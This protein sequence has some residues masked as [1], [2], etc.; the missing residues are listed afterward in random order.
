MYKPHPLFECPSDEL[1]IWRYMDLFKF[2]DILNY[3]ALYLPR[4][5]KLVKLDE[6][7]GGLRPAYEEYISE[8]LFSANFYEFLC[9]FGRID[10][11]LITG[12]KVSDL[13]KIRERFMEVYNYFKNN[14]FV[15]FWHLNSDENLDMWNEYIYSPPGVAV[16]SSVGK[17]KQSLETTDIP[18][19]LSKVLYTDW[20][21]NNIDFN[22]I[23]CGAGTFLIILQMLFNKA[24]RYKKENELRILCTTLPDDKIYGP[25]LGG[26]FNLKRTSGESRLLLPIES[27][28]L[29]DKI[30]L[31]PGS[32]PEFRN[33]IIHLV[34]KYIRGFDTTKIVFSKFSK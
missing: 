2:E 6:Y 34:S 19:T 7:E 12:N 17:L 20:E 15:N 23:F 24:T 3:R 11:I 33:E 21:N 26:G 1:E 5:D 10:D 32:T 18:I 28:R 22:I 13:K 4:A 9:G 14:I 16:V 27:T 25:L 31:S 29:I 8:K 30:Y